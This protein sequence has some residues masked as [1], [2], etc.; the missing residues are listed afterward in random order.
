MIDAI[1][2]GYVGLLLIWIAF[3]LNIS[4][5]TNTDSV[6]YNI[7]NLLGGISLTYYSSTLKSIPFIILQAVWAIF[8]LFNLIRISTRK[9]KI[10]FL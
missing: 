3:T 8:A 7:L 6:L 1:Y 2:F 9:L 5:K 10:N 4:K